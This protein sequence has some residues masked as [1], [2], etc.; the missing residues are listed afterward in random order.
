MQARFEI[1]GQQMRQH[2]PHV[3]VVALL[4]V[5]IGERLGEIGGDPNLPVGR[6]DAGDRGVDDPGCSGDRV[7]VRSRAR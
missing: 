1:V 2:L 7:D 3:N 5:D 4:N 6:D